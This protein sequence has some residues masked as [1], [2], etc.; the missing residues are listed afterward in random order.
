MTKLGDIRFFNVTL[1]DGHLMC[2]PKHEP[3]FSFVGSLLQEIERGEPRV[4]LGADDIQEGGLQA[5]PPP[6]E[7]GP[8][9]VPNRGRHRQ[10]PRRDGW[11]TGV[12]DV[13]SEEEGVVQ[14]GRCDIEGR[15]QP[16]DPSPARDGDPGDVGRRQG[17]AEGPA[18]VQE[19]RRRDRAGQPGGLHVQG[20]EDAEGADVEEARGRPGG[21][22]RE[23]PRRGKD[24]TSVLPARHRGP[25]L[26]RPRAGR[27][28]SRA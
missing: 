1:R 3:E 7:V 16:G 14:E 26:L 10:D 2:R 11:G 4:R 28:A 13:P 22:L 27:A 25:A 12:H 21:V 6:T 23:V 8:P 20:P 19:L 17:A 5:R 24:G 15:G 9:R 18:H